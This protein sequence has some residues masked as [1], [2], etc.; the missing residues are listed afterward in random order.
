[1]LRSSAAPPTS[2]SVCYVGYVGYAPPTSTSAEEPDVV[3]VCY[4]GYTLAE[5]ADVVHRI[6]RV[7]RLQGRA[8]LRGG[9][10]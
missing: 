5:E 6:R 1:M 9:A 8:A 10:V 3:R 7:L 4:V 2:T